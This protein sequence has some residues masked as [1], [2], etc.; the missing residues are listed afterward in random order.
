[1]EK[2][3]E[4]NNDNILFQKLRKLTK[5]LAKLSDYGINESIKFPRICFLGSISS[6]KSSVLESLLDFGFVQRG[7]GIVTR[8]P[9]EIRLRHSDN[10]E[11]YVIFEERNEEKYSD[12]KKVEETIEK[13][14]DEV[15]RDYRAISDKPIILYLYSKI[16]PDLTL[17]DLPGLKRFSICV[18]PRNIDDLD[19]NIAKRYI[20][21]SLTLI[22]CVI[23][24]NSDIC[25][26]DS[27]RIAKEIDETGE[28]TIGVLAKIDIMDEGTDAGK[29]LLNEEV[30][31]KLGYIGVINRSKQDRNN[32]LPLSESIKKE[33]EFFQST[34]PYKDLPSEI[35]GRNSLVNKITQTYFKLMREDLERIKKVINDKINKTEGEKQSSSISK[36]DDVKITLMNLLK[37]NS[38]LFE[39]I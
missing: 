24:A 32:K 18:V 13:L 17:I 30:P 8:R 39:G 35:L 11:P 29:S 6:G 26:S 20:D 7:D 36:D 37:D 14:T 25:T 38:D 15:C 16:C 22:V 27:L 9:L 1:M 19:R 21:D 31:L 10:L 3:S 23:S 2:N 28:R 34:P 33:K 12:F 4:N 5:F